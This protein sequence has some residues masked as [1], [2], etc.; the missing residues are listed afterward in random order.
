MTTWPLRQS[1]ITSALM[2]TVDASSVPVLRL[3][4]K[5]RIP[6]SKFKVGYPVVT[7]DM[8]LAEVCILKPENRAVSG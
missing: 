2:Q 7:D 5:D 1:G 4:S 8:T 3:L 6:H